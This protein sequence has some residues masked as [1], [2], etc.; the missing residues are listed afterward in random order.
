MVW[1][2]GPPH[3]S[4]WHECSCTIP[5]LP[6]DFVI[7]TRSSVPSC[8][9]PSRPI[10]SVAARWAAPALTAPARAGH[11]DAWV[12]TKKRLPGRTKKLRD[13][14]MDRTLGAPLDK[15]R[16]HTSQGQ[17]R[18]ST[19]AKSRQILGLLYLPRPEACGLDRTARRMIDRALR[20]AAT[21]A[22]FPTRGRAPRHRTSCRNAGSPACPRPASWRHRVGRDRCRRR[23]F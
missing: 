11:S 3:T 21:E 7:P 6:S 8:S 19:T 2:F 16:P 12:G 4:M 15:N 22:L 23:G 17:E 5:Q 14:K 9:E 13:E 1:V 10:L 18:L 20:L